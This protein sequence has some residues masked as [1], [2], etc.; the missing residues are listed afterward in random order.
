M[1]DMIYEDNGKNSTPIHV[2]QF[3]ST[4]NNGGAENRM[5]DVYRC[6]DSEIVIFDFAV[7]HEGD[8]FFDAEVSAGNS[9]KYVLPD[10]RDGLIKNYCALVKFFRTH[11][12]QA[13]H[14]HVAWY[15]GI[16]LL[17]AK[18]AGVKIRIAHARDAAMPNRSLKENI[19]CGIG[20]CLI[21]ISATQRIAISAEA[22]ANIFGKRCA[23]KKR[24]LFVPNSIDQNKYA[25]LNSD[26]RNQLRK[27]LAIPEGIKAYV[28]VA[29]LRSQKNHLF[30][31]DIAKELQCRNDPFILYLIGEGNLRGKIEAKIKQ[32]G[33]EHQVI[34][35]GNRDDVPRILCAFDCM[36]FPSLFEGLG[37][38]VLEAQLVGVPAVVSDRIPPVADVGINMVEFLSLE[39][40]A[41][42]WANAVIKKSEK[43]QW[44][45]EAARE[46]F[47]KKGYSIEE[48]AMCYLREYG[49]KE[50]LVKKAVLR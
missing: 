9:Q 32:L 15:S 17:A 19:V 22:A 45:R 25:V 1:N 43:F 10:P 36:I 33:L 3:F 48:T 26:E 13:V 4:L 46:A 18:R 27:T 41:D 6:I 7:V 11:E 40:S 44:S 42:A 31:L 37:G 49:L 24:F 12:F 20:S 35:M 14:A 28:T 23:R 29:N 8:Q 16:V 21:K 34:L 47:R 2:L 38:V 50:D 39:E 5:M 30:L